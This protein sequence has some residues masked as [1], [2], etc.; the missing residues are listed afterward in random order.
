MRIF[1][2]LSVLRETKNIGI[3]KRVSGKDAKICKDAK[4]LF[5][6][7]CVKIDTDGWKGRGT[8]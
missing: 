8:K 5:A 2:D 1:A 6:R 7:G 3:E 4:L